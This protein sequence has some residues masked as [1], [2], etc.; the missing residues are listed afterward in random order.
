[1]IFERL[2]QKHIML[3]HIYV[4]CKGKSQSYWADIYRSDVPLYIGIVRPKYYA[5]YDNQKE[6]N[7]NILR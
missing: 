5:I 6:S 7:T 4:V 3:V 1:M 2:I